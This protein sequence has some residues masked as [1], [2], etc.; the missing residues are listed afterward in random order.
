MNLPRT[1]YLKTTADTKQIKFGKICECMVN[2]WIYEIETLHDC[3][4][5][6]ILL[7]LFREAGIYL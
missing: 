1:V 5:I 7:K 6:L 2:G 4:V 3:L